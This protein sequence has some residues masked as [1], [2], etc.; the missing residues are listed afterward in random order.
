MITLRKVLSAWRKRLFAFGLIVGL[1]LFLRQVWVTFTAIQ[2]HDLASTRGSYLLA[3]LVA[4]LSIYA[5]MM[6]AWPLLMRYLGASLSIRH[7]V[8]GYCLTFIPRYIP[9]SVWG[10]LSRSQWLEQAHDIKY[11]VSLMGSV[12]EGLGLLLTGLFMAGLFLCSQLVGTSQ[13]LLALAC[14]A[15]LVATWL[16]VPRI[17]LQLGRRIAGET[18]VLPQGQH[19]SM[20]A[21]SAVIVLYLLLWVAF[22][23]SLLFAGNAMLPYPINDLPA[24]VFVASLSWVLG[25]VIVFV[26]AGLGVRE[27]AIST[28]LIAYTALLPWQADLVAVISRF[29]LIVAELAWLLIG[30][31]LFFRSKS[32]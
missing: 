27:L 25:F 11:G 12:L 24:A 6:L 5:L 3:A 13:L 16:I 9:G 10:Y 22:G 2:H 31:A 4:N 32:E 30:L 26:P 8:Q 23:A 14:I 7:T 1:A 19:S 17:A 18:F 20:G 21:W 15:L 28:L 29:G